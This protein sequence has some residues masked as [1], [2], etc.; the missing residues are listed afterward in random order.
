VAGFSRN[1]WPLSS[2][3]AGRIRQEYAQRPDAR[4]QLPLGKKSVPDDLMPALPAFFTAHHRQ[5]F[6]YFML[7]GLLEHPPRP[8][9]DESCDLRPVLR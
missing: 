8:L 7:Q 6:R 9:P 2:G 3:I 5:K 1:P 4:D